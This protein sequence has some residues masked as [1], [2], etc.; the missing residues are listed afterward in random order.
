MGRPTGF[1]RATAVLTLAGAGAFWVTNL[2]IS[3]TPLAARY[4]DA[5]SIAY[6][7]MLLEALVGGLVLGFCVAVLLLR[8][9]DRVPTRSCTTRAVVLSTA[10][11]VVVTLLVEVPAKFGAAAP[12]D[13]WRWF[14]VGLLF[15]ALR[16]TALGVAIG[17]LHGG[18]EHETR[19]DRAPEPGRRRARRR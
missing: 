2:A 16:I 4:R 19:A 6:L 3:L 13:P 11:L 18:L 5:L 8:L 9:G 14:L 10:A 12:S 15:N 17:R 7:P 1:W